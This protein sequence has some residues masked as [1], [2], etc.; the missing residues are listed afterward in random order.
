MLRIWIQLDPF[1]FGL[2]DLDP[3][4][5]NEPE[6]NTDPEGKNT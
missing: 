4:P 5:Y 6:L 3:D 1:H 2:P